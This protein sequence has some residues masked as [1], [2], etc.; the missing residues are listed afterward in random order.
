MDNYPKFTDPSYKHM[1]M[2]G[3]SLI[4][5]LDK[6]LNVNFSMQTSQKIHPHFN[7]KT[8]KIFVDHLVKYWKNP[9]YYVKYETLSSL[10]TLTGTDY[11]CEHEPFK[12]ALNAIGIKTTSYALPF[13]TKMHMYPG[14]V[15]VNNKTIFL[16][17]SIK[18]QLLQIW[19]QI[20]NSIEIT[21]E[22]TV[23]MTTCGSMSISDLPFLTRDEVISHLKKK[24][25]Y[26]PI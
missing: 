12:S 18:K 19:E 2:Q 7:E 20:T 8:K 4:K 3:K 15:T 16:N 13:K 5:T 23:I 9:P 26:T 24:L 25:Q 1:E 14:Y 22:S 11:G 17:S 6:M 10:I 21:D